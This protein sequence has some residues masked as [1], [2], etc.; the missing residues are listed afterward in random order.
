MWYVAN[1]YQ[2]IQI[3][4]MQWILGGPQLER[5]GSTNAQFVWNW[6]CRY[7]N[8]AEHIL[9]VHTDFHF[10]FTSNCVFYSMLPVEF[11]EYTVSM[12]SSFYFQGISVSTFC[13]S[14]NRISG[15]SCRCGLFIWWYFVITSNKIIKTISVLFAVSG[16]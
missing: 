10:F 4:I 6:E 13:L 14:C 2:L 12:E 16:S 15:L 9:N 8:T 1:L 3:T 7:V 11:L 5:M